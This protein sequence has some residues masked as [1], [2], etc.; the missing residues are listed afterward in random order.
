MARSFRD[1][2][3]LT[4]LMF[5]AFAV[6]G[7]ALS[8]DLEG[9]SASAMGP[10]YFP[11]LVSGILLGLGILITA[12]GLLSGANNPTG[13]WT[14][15]PLAFISVAAILFAVLLHRAGLVVAIASCIFVGSFAGGSPRLIQIAALIV[16]LSLASVS[17]FVWAMG[18]PL[19]IWPTWRM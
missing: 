11:R 16:V 17:L 2:D 6:V 4:G 5:I 19:P 1:A 3:V 10:G 7:F 8:S 12:V 15:R 14:V 13:G 9:G 18:I